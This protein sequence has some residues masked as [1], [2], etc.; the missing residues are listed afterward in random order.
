MMM[1]QPMMQQPAMMMQQPV[2]QMQPM[3]VTVPP[4]MGPG[5]VFVVNTSGGPMQVQVPFG[6]P[7]QP[8]GQMVMT[9]QVPIQTTQLVVMQQPVTAMMPMA[10][11]VQQVVAPQ[12]VQPQVVRVAADPGNRTP[13][14]FSH[15]GR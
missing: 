12:Q 5:S 10:P 9:I 15:H 6:L 4:G 2:T 8:N 11:V 7:M 3:Q 14:S 1:Q 13:F